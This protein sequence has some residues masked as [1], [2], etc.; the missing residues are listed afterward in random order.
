MQA[1]ELAEFSDVHF[2]LSRRGEVGKGFG[3]GL[4]ADLIGQSDIRTMARIARLAAMAVRFTAT[5]RG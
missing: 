3:N 4:A 5:P 1:L 2:G